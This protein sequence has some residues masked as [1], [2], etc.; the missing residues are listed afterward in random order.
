MISR[1]LVLLTLLS[2]LQAFQLFKGP[3]LSK[4]YTSLL[5]LKEDSCELE[6][7]LGINCGNWDCSVNAE[8]VGYTAVIDLMTGNVLYI[9][10][11]D[12]DETDERE[13]CTE[14]VTATVTCSDPDSCPLETYET[15]DLFITMPDGTIT[16]LLGVEIEDGV[17]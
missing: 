11:V 9:T 2:T 12:E 4:S 3:E 17:L 5:S 8:V 16:E 10:V 6:V 1:G 7:P 14:F 15:A 13:N